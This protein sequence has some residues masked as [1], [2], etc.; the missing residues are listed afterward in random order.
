MK[1]FYD[2]MEFDFER[3]LHS[4]AAEECL[5]DSILKDGSQVRYLRARLRT[6]FHSGANEAVTQWLHEVRSDP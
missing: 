1:A 5:D 2:R 3:W 4:Q 6:A